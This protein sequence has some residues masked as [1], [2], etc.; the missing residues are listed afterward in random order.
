[1]L[2]ERCDGSEWL[3]FGVS[4]LF[5]GV[6]S[7]GQDTKTAV[8]SLETTG[9]EG[10]IRRCKRNVCVLHIRPLSQKTTQQ[11]YM[12]LRRKASACGKRSEM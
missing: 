1:M 4:I 8:K 2:S 3:N 7:D 12:C 11:P 10:P 5:G 6:C 9:C